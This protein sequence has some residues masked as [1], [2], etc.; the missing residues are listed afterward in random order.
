[1][2]TIAST[3]VQR[4]RPCFLPLAVAAVGGVGFLVSWA[5]GSWL[6]AALTI[7]SLGV[8]GG[9]CW[10]LRRRRVRPRS[11]SSAGEPAVKEEVRSRARRAE[12]AADESEDLIE[13]MLR[14]G[15]YALLLRPQIVGNLNEPQVRNALEDLEAAM[16]LTPEGTVLLRTWRATAEHDGDP[17]DD[18][19]MRVE[20][21]Y[22]DRYP[23]TN[24]EYLR[25]VEAGGYEQ[26]SLW[27]P[28]IWSGILDFVDRSGAPGPGEWENGRYAPGRDDHPV[29]GVSWYEAAAYARWVG[30]R[31]PT[32]A[33]WVK[34]A[35]WPV[36]NGGGR[37]MQRKYPWGD[38]MDHTF[39]NLW[40]TQIGDTLPVSKLEE[41]VS[42]GGVYQL[43]GN[44]WEW[45]HSNF[46]AWDEAAKRLEIQGAMKSIRGGAF[47]TYF[48]SQATCQFQSGDSSIARKHNIGFRCCLGLCD[49]APNFA[50]DWS[51][52]GAAQSEG[53]ENETGALEAAV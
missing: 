30:K 11:E 23:V 40:A 3:L 27:D 20:A 22:L 38:A 16:A 1:M 46:G 25:F 6:L 2:T 36:G 43:I 7:A 29:V 44:V 8:A 17:S 14:Q 9:V 53:V 18:H 41:G 28:D 10:F 50:E 35:S 45:T 21:F 26:M 33:E 19:V 42:V 12:N 37:P 51:A 15:R 34:A 24:R 47:D 31:L 48:D 49:L 13:E 5:A 4:V 32:D 39:A 52:P